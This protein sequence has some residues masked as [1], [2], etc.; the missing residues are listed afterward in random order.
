M[1]RLNRQKKR[2]QFTQRVNCCL[3]LSLA[4]PTA[5]GCHA[6]ST[7]ATFFLATKPH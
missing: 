1:T 6:R 3:A 5:V 2:S 7:C 4:H